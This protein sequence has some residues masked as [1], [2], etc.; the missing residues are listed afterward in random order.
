MVPITALYAALLVAIFVVLTAKVGAQRRRSGTSILDGGDL[1]LGLAMRKH[2]NFAEYVPLALV[3]MAL[4]EANGGNAAFLHTAGIVLVLSRIVHPIG[5][6][7][8]EMAT[9]GRIAGA[10]GTLLMI[11]AL[12][13]VALWQGVGALASS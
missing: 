9:P 13:V 7:T 1:A 6:R 11:L 8:D 2:G 3:L 5:L 4:V 12:A 10:G